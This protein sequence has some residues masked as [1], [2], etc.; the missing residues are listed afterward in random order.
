LDSVSKFFHVQSKKR[1]QARGEG[2]TGGGMEV[3]N[4]TTGAVAIWWCKALRS[5]IQS[6]FSS[7]NIDKLASEQSRRPDKVKPKYGENGTLIAPGKDLLPDN[8][9]FSDDPE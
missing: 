6:V 1:G 3:E 2:A 8:V 7:T 4:M 5:E 9:T